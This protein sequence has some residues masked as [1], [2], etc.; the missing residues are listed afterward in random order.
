MERGRRKKK[1]KKKKE[2]ERERARGTSKATCTLSRTDLLGDPAL[3]LAVNAQARRRP[4]L[5]T[6]GLLLRDQLGLLL[7]AQLRLRHDEKKKKK[8]GYANNFRG[9]W[10]LKALAAGFLFD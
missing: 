10:F 9:G 2:R 4:V 3:L 6:L 7:L 5:G 1:K 8:I